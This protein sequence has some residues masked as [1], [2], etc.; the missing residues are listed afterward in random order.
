MASE[1]SEPQHLVHGAWLP[2]APA[3]SRE[4]VKVES[5]PPSRPRFDS[6][7]TS[8]ASGWLGSCDGKFSTSQPIENA[9]NRKKS[10]KRRRAAGRAVSSSVLRFLGDRIFPRCRPGLFGERQAHDQ[11]VRQPIDELDIAAVEANNFARDRQAEAE[12]AAAGGVTRAVALEKRLEDLFTKVRGNARPVIRHLDPTF[13]HARNSDGHDSAVPGG[14]V[15]DIGDRSGHRMGAAGESEPG[16]SGIG[17]RVADIGE[18]RANG[19][20]RLGSS[21]SERLRA[22]AV[23]ENRRACRRACR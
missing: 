7:K 18:L 2:C 10:R 21:T 8:S 11:S 22:A 5:D 15:D 9:Q 23:A 16:R 20:Q 14:V 4:N 12:T 1:A 17:H 3:E 13:P 6:A 19:L